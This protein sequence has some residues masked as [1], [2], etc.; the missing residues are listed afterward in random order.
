MPPNVLIVEDE[1]IIAMDL[2]MALEGIGYGVLGTAASYDEALALAEL[3]RPDVVLL[4][5]RL[6][7]QKDGVELAVALRA[8]HQVPLVYLTA[9]RDPATMHRAVQTQP[10]GF[11]AKPFDERT[12]E[13]TIALALHKHKVA[14]E[15]TRAHEELRRR[16]QEL[17]LLDEM[18]ASLSHCQ[19]EHQIP[20]V[21]THLLR[22]LF[23]EVKSRVVIGPIDASPDDAVLPLGDNDE[24]LGA[25]VF[26]G[27]RAQAFI[28]Q[29]GS[30]CNVV[31]RRIAA[32]VANLRAKEKLERDAI[33]DALTGLYN[34]RQLDLLLARELSQAARHKRPLGVMLIDLDHFKKLN[35]LYGH[36]AGDRVLREVAQALK[37]RVRL[38]DSPCRYGGE[39]LAVLLPATDAAGARVV[40]EDLRRAIRGLQITH[41][42]QALPMVTASFGIA[43]FPYH[44]ATAEELIRNADRALYAAKAA[45]RD[46][47]VVS[48]G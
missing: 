35:D 5:I 1:H 3:V 48:E 47:I 8:R 23:P 20:S 42:G 15:M 14:A 43:T 36:A 13:S 41:E 12:L 46:R 38:D 28:E 22:T 21:V 9:N 24:T 45:G 11:L 4:D 29:R 10:E 17:A 30:L 40:G 16:T 34:R 39:E 26:E 31:A 37:G 19:R 6:E 7:G 27:A 33:V 25:L 32:S 18:G 2:Q 44:G